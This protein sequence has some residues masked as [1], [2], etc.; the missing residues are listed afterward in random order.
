[1]RLTDLEPQFV[2]YEDRVE[3]RE[4]VD[5]DEATWRERGCPTVKRTLPCQYI[6]PVA[7]LAE[8]QGIHFLCPVCFQQNGGAVG[9]HLCSVTFEGRGAQDHHGS[10]GKDGKPTR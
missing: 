3:E 2:R 7:T 10:H 9:T 1:M 6:I 8:A 4:F 5:G